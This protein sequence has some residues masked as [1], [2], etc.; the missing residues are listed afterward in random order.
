MSW[1]RLSLWPLPT[2]PPPLK[3]GLITP[4]LQYRIRLELSTKPCI[5]LCLYS[6][7]I[8]DRKG[9]IGGWDWPRKWGGEPS[10]CY[11]ML[12]SVYISEHVISK[13][14]GKGSCLLL[15]CVNLFIYLNQITNNSKIKTGM[16]KFCVLLLSL[17]NQLSSR[18]RATQKALVRHPNFRRNF[19]LFFSPWKV[20]NKEMAH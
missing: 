18:K 5:L 13:L 10:P 20:K 14:C 11:L 16:W 3:E 2:E 4:C 19:S 6:V 17:N 7:H 15:T 1:S 8:S 12:P 9:A